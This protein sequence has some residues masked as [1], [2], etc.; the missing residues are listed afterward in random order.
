MP[1]RMS[2]Q[3]L[4]RD[5][6]AHRLEHAAC[7]RP[8]PSRCSTPTCSA[9]SSGRY[10]DAG[11]MICSLPSS[12]SIS[13]ATMRDRLRHRSDAEDRVARH[14]RFAARSRK[15]N[16][17][18]I[19]DLAVAHDQ[20][21]RARNRAALDVGVE[22]VG[23]SLQ[24]RRGKAQLLQA[25]RARGSGAA[26]A[27]CPATDEQRRST[28]ALH[29]AFH[30]VAPRFKRVRSRSTHAITTNTASVLMHV[31][32]KYVLVGLPMRE[33]RHRKQR[34]DRAVVRQRVHAAARHRGDAMQDF[35]RDA[36]ALR[37][38]HE[39]L[40][41]RGER[42]AHASGRRA[43]DAGQRRHGDRFVHERI[44]NRRQRVA[45]RRGIPATP[46]S[47]RRSRTPTR[48]SS[49]RAARRRSRPSC[50]RRISARSALNANASDGDE[51][52]EQ[53]AHAPPRSRRPRTTASRAAARVPRAASP[54]PVRRS[55]ES[56]A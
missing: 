32:A 37:G 31:I 25:T 39:L 38:G 47:P 23:Q 56:R 55:A 40:R 8:H 19:R 41:H 48:C 20:H 46:R 11:S 35:G 4:H 30:R 12:A 13:A 27:T 53:R 28:Q 33:A 9:L 43:G 3:I 26:L 6:A 44:G 14:R 36:R 51:C 2:H 17:F 10:V 7:A 34:D 16:V 50:L 1:G 24:P 21:D 42:D 45:D 22:R 52:R 18:V 15:P 49:T 54:R 29:R 5:L